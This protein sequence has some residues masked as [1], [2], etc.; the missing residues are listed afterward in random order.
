MKSV[1]LL[2][3]CLAI[4]SLDAQ[5][6]ELYRWMDSKGVMHYS[7]TPPPKSEQAEIKKISNSEGSDE[8]L[9]FE[10]RRAKQ[11]FPHAVRRIWLQRYM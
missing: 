1:I 3:G 8:G 6:G 11:N 5:A 9:S 2:L 7:D 4:L 10:T